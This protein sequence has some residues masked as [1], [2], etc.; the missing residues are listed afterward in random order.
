[1][2]EELEKM[3]EELEKVKQRCKEE[4]EQMKGELGR[5]DGLH[6]DAVAQ[7]GVL[8]EERD[9]LEWALTAQDEKFEELKFYYSSRIPDAA[10]DRDYSGE[11]E[12]GEEEGEAAEAPATEEEEEEE[13]EEEA[14][15]A[16]DATAATA[17]EEEE[18][19][20]IE[21]I[22]LQRRMLHPTF[23][24]H[25]HTYSNPHS[26]SPLPSSPTLRIP[27]FRRRRR[28]PRALRL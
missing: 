16:A 28:L 14:A 13:E 21:S 2:K 11:G 26:S 22:L 6:S 9:E 7:C 5:L 1:V 17:A 15:A 3:R 10:Q 23:T 8:E 4:G 25:L 27:L 19:S 20:E 18:V 24:P 12:D